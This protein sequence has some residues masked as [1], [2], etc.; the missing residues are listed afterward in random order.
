MVRCIALHGDRRRGL[1]FSYDDDDDD[2]EEE[3]EG[4]NDDDN[5]LNTVADNIM[6]SSTC[7]KR[8]IIVSYRMRRD[9]QSINPSTVL[10][11]II[12]ST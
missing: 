9:G 4:D 7:C 5:V 6:I 11:S 3:E 1:S 2:D 8:L 10:C 12:S